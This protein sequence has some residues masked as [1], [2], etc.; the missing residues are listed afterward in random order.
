MVAYYSRCSSTSCTSC[1][2]IYTLASGVVKSLA[3]L[4]KYDNSV[5]IVTFPFSFSVRL[6]SPVLSYLPLRFIIFTLHSLPFT[7]FHWFSFSNPCLNLFDLFSFTTILHFFFVVFYPFR[8]FFFPFLSHLRRAATKRP[9]GNSVNHESRGETISRT[10]RNE[11]ENAGAMRS[12]LLPEKFH[13][14]FR[15]WIIRA[16]ITP[17]MIVFPEEWNSFPRQMK[18]K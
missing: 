6:F 5:T 13:L 7:S 16:S 10:G 4:Y 14:C 8:R 18:W 12:S 1:K 2:R 11:A 17:V 3:R 15:L 9:E